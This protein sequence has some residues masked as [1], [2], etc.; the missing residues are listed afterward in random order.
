MLQN[1]QL[2]WNGTN[3]TGSNW[4]CR[5]EYDNKKFSKLLLYFFLPRPKS[6]EFGLEDFFLFHNFPKHK[7]RL[8][9][10][11]NIFFIYF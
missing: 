11:D 3:I 10:Y 1:E 7:I 2:E 5:S 4:F 6:C 9:I 8:S